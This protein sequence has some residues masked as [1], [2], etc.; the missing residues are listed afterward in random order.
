MG[1]ANCNEGEIDC[2]HFLS[3]LKYLV[4]KLVLTRQKTAPYCPVRHKSHAN[5]HDKTENMTLLKTARMQRKIASH[6]AA[7]SQLL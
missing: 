3:T 1:A 6:F 2:K 5:A 7:H 4:A